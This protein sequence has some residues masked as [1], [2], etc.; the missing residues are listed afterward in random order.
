LVLNAVDATPAGGE[1]EVSAR[2]AHLHD[3][4]GVAVSVRD[5]GLGIPAEL[6]PRVFEPFFTTKPAGRGTGL[7]LAICR[8]IVKAHGGDLKVESREGQGTTFTAWIPAAADGAS[9]AA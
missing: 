1:V 4:A 6:L 8:D 9:S 2:H 7:G 5:S 3:R